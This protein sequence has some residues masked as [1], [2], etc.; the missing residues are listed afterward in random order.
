MSEAVLI[1]ERD[2]GIVTL[3][4]NRPHVMTAFSSELRATVTRTFE[5]L[6]RDTD[7]R[8]VII[9]GAGRAFSTGNDLKELSAP[10]A[11]F[12]DGDG[13]ALG[14]KMIQTI[15]AFDR[16]IIGAINGP[17]ITGGFELALSCDIRIASTEARFADTHSRVGLLP[18]WGLSQ[19]LPRLIGSGRAKE[20]SFTGNFLSAEQ[21]EA[22]GLVNRVVTPEDLMPTCMAVA[23]DIVSCVSETVLEYKQLIDQGGSMTLAQGLQLE[24]KAY[25]EQ[26]SRFSSE[27][28]AARRETILARGRKQK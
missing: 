25:E 15:D 6:K 14:A 20:L 19:K 27:D 24:R 17:A 16:P 5:D 2:E 7:I 23:R 28:V 13:R 18:G 8:V 3:I 26:A 22:W 9:T 21:A 12:H 4:L 11:S 10:G 1:V